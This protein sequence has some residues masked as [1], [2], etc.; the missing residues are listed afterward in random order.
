[1]PKRGMTTTW[2]LQGTKLLISILLTLGACL[3]LTSGALCR[4]EALGPRTQ[5]GHD[6]AIARY[7]SFIKAH[8][9]DPLE[10]MIDLF[11]AHDVVILAERDHRE[12]TQWE[13]IYRLLEDPRFNSQVG[14]LFTEYG[15][16]TQQGDLEEYM[17]GERPDPGRI[18]TKL[19]EIMKS[20]APRR[21]ALI[22]MNTRHAFRAPL[23]RDGVCYGDNVGSALARCH[24]TCG[25]TA[26]VMLNYVSR[27]RRP[28]QDASSEMPVRDGKWDAAFAALGNAPRAVTFHDSPFGDDDFDYLGFSP[29]KLRYRDVFDGMVFYEPL[30]R[31]RL[32]E[33]IPGFYDE[34]FRAIV[35]NRA[36]LNDSVK[37]MEE[38][39]NS[40]RDHPEKFNDRPA[41]GPE[42]ME[43]VSRWLKPSASEMR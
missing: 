21:K 35:R 2:P 25:R 27:K 36:L 10:Y 12:T 4:E 40:M 1:M 3:A 19:A 26:F 43:T 34:T 7:V 15:S 28:G 16:V 11:K 13:F 6:P 17:A 31:H 29:M 14:Y 23:T 5:A 39:W 24:P 9:Q 8:G 18:R 37:E 32:A 42:I 33:N 20:Q 22:I 30:T 41:Y 38:L